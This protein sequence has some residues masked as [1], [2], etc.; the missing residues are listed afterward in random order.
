[1]K[2]PRPETIFLDIDGCILK[3]HGSLEQQATCEPELLPGVREK[4]D[5]WDRK[6]CRIILTTGRRESLRGVTTQ[7]LLQFGLPYDVLLM[8]I[9]GA[10]RILINDKKPD[11]EDAAL[12]FNVERNVGL[13]DVSF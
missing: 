2:D 3:H 12:A 9:S 13:G 4:M 6:G 8:G 7:Q 5:E 10:R 11:G 1:M